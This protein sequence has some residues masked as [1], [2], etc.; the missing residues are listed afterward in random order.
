M[1]QDGGRGEALRAFLA[2]HDEPCPACGYNLRGLTGEACPECGE[3]L[4]LRVGMVEPRMKL[5]LGGLVGLACGTG[6]DGIILLW[7]VYEQVW[8]GGV[9]MDLGESMPL[10]VG[11]AVCGG[12]MAWWLR[13]RVWIRHR[14]VGMRWLLVAGCWALS[15]LAGIAFFASVA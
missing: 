15:G 8:G 9:G 5:Y 11:L 2:E 12:A 3:A 14:S 4:R 10:I 13:A 1:D 6:F 7:V